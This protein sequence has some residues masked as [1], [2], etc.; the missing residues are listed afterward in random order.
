MSREVCTI[1]ITCEDK[2]DSYREEDVVKT[3]WP[4]M[5]PFF[6]R[7]HGVESGKMSLGSGV[8]ISWRYET[9]YSVAE[10][11]QILDDTECAP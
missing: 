3:Y 5:L 4:Y 9:I 1:T 8:E 11:A 6:T 2:N 7:R 10:L